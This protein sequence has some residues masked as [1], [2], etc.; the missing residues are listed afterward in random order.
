MRRLLWA[1]AFSVSAWADPLSDARKAIQAEYDCSNRA[2]DQGDVEKAFACFSP[3]FVFTV[4][5]GKR[6]G[7]KELKERQK[8][9]MKRC[10]NLHSSSKIV[11]IQLQGSIAL[12]QVNERFEEMAPGFW[13]GT[14]TPYKSTDTAQDTWRKTADGWKITSSTNLVQHSSY[15]NENKHEK[16]G[17]LRV[18]RRDG[19][20]DSLEAQIGTFRNSKGQLVDLVSA[21]H[22][23]EHSYYQQ[24]N[25]EFKSYDAVLYELIAPDNVVPEANEPSDNALSDGQ[26]L[27]TNMLGLT[28]QLNEI[29]YKAR[30][31]VHADLTPEQLFASMDKRGESAKQMIFQILQ[32]SLTDTADIDPADALALNLALPRIMVRGAK[33]SDH[34]LLRRVF[35]AS[36]EKI[37]KITSGL[38]GPNGS[39]LITVRN[40]RA[41]EVMQRQFARGR[42]RLAI[43]YGAGHMVDLEG[44]LKKLGFQPQSVR[45]IKAWDLREPKP[46]EV[47][48]TK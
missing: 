20:P 31:F 28:F 23:G 39:T 44:R 17:Y 11:K 9:R 16:V 45:F 2:L 46:P 41:I 12:V 30:N 38:S 47:R 43:F 32:E 29:N 33:A 13:P 26:M 5:S 18:I 48:K 25:Q 1:L 8:Q 27:L 42:R 7:L 34:A 3:D 10:S 35:A 36:F 15:R 21:L 6:V 4:A 22:V 40:Q 24:L 19:R 37:E 14:K